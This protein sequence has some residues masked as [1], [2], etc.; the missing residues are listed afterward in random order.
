MRTEDLITKL[1]LDLKPTK[2]MS[3]AP[4]FLAKW[5]LMMF[6][7]SM[8][9]IL[10]MPGRSDLQFN[11]QSFYLKLFVWFSLSLMAAY[12]A[13]LSHIPGVSIKKSARA[14]LLTGSL[15]ILIALVD[16][17]SGQPVTDFA[18][19][20]NLYRSVCG[21]FIFGMTVVS[22][23]SLIS[24]FRQGASTQPSWTSWWIGIS[25]GC[26]S[27]LALSFFCDHGEVAHLLLWHALPIG[28]ISWAC[29]L[30]GRRILR[31]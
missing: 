24:Y 18:A 29:S 27:S 31:W 6:S 16:V 4:K 19:E 2:A 15:F 23:G 3:S 1:T 13:Y 11:T 26:F 25:A 28:L 12:T 8:I 10:L 22:A 14:T 21:M 5:F 20:I 7:I 17:F 30:V 9:L